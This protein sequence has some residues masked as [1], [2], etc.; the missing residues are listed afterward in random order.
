MS[1]ALRIRSGSGCCDNGSIKG[2]IADHSSKIAR[3]LDRLN[4]SIKAQDM[5][6]P[7]YKIHQLSGKEKGIYSVWVNGNWR[8]TFKFEDGDAYIV[9]YRDY[10]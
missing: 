9:D 7:S 3:T 4:A 6:L 5:N 1:A 2:I 10:H 8:I